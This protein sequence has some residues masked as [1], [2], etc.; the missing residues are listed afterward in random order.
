MN[1]YEGY[2]ISQS[3]DSDASMQ[4]ARHWLDTCT[5]FHKKR[6][7]PASSSLPTRVLD[8]W[9]SD[10]LDDADMIR[11]IA[12][13]ENDA[14]YVA[15]SYCWGPPKEAKLVKVTTTETLSTH[16]AGILVGEL[17]KNFQ[18]AILITRKLNIRYLWIDSLCII[19][20]SPLDWD[21]EAG[22]MGDYYER[23]TIALSALCSPS[24]HTGFLHHRW[25]GNSRVDFRLE[26]YETINVRKVSSSLGSQGREKMPLWKRAWV[27]QERC[28]S[29]R[30]L[31]FGSEQMYWECRQSFV[32][33]DGHRAAMA[34]DGALMGPG[35]FVPGGERLKE[36]SYGRWYALIAAYSKRAL[37]KEDDRLPALGGIAVRFQKVTKSDYLAGLWKDDIIRGLLWCRKNAGPRSPI[38]QQKKKRLAKEIEI[39]SSQRESNSSH[40]VPSWSWAAIGNH[41]VWDSTPQIAAG[42]LSATCEVIEAKVTSLGP[43]HLGRVTQSSL[44]L[45][46]FLAQ[47]PLMLI[48]THHGSQGHLTKFENTRICT[49]MDFIG[50]DITYAYFLYVANDTKLYYWLAISQCTPSEGQY[51]RVGL[52]RT[53]KAAHGHLIKDAEQDSVTII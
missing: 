34:S 1:P 26:N 30:I 8:V 46:G 43:V 42:Q 12:T 16:M 20:D 14:P 52:L 38:P 13:V 25:L 18:D 5:E 6:C 36:K 47:S 24:S 21:K 19:Q 22:K 29:S 27:V 48:T 11:L 37:T 4:L 44:H 35:C 53:N 10:E 7:G 49:T 15:L 45:R 33:E 3:A 28:L 41:V 9:G 51:R 17:P 31:H 32:R 2:E 23:A 39:G 40:E 50:G